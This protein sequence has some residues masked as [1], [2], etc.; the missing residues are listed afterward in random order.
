MTCWTLF[1]VSASPVISPF[2]HFHLQGSPAE[3]TGTFDAAP[4]KRATHIQYLHP[5]SW[6]YAGQDF[7]YSY[8]GMNETKQ[9]QQLNKTI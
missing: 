2:A 5:V 1:P 3:G 7:I 8:M 6:C 4:G 9:L